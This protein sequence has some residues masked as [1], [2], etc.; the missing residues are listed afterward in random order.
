MNL[1]IG[2]VNINNGTVNNYITSVDEPFVGTYE[3]DGLVVF[4]DE[5]L[6]GLF[7]A[8]FRERIG[9]IPVNKAECIMQCK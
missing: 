9:V 7:L 3:G 8:S 4:E 6:N 2:T 5:E 1:S